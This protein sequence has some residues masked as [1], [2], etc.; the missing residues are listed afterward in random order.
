M[1]EPTASLRLSNWIGGVPCPPVSGE[2]FENL[3]PATSELLCEV[4]RSR[5][6]DVE[7]AVEAAREGAR[8]WGDV[9]VPER[10]QL[11]DRVADLI[12][13]RAESLATLES[14]DQGKPRSLAARIDIPRAA[15]NFR[16]FAGALVTR[17]PAPGRCLEP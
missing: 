3:N 14:R 8:I 11:L 13:A 5:A 4:P 1:A 2:H 9:S 15:A 17:A 12:D 10:A 7:R 6:A 16:F